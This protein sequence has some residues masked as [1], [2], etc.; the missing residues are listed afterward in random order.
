MKKHII[1][2]SDIELDNWKDFLETLSELEYLSDD[3]KQII[4]NAEKLDFSNL[5]EEKLVRALAYFVFR[6]CSESDNEEEFRIYLA[7]SIA[8]TLLIGNI[9]KEMP[10]EEAARIVSEEIEYSEDNTETIK[11]IFY[12]FTGVAFGNAFYYSF[13]NYYWNM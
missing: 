6:H 9:S 2:S 1:W 12:W 11:S 13:A 3:H 10:I 8:L 5:S 4:C 7:F